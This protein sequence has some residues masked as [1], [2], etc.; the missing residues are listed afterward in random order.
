M[1]SVSEIE[2][3]LIKRFFSGEW[4]D[5]PKS[6]S[7]ASQNVR[8]PVGVRNSIEAGKFECPNQ[9]CFGR[10]FEFSDTRVFVSAAVPD[11]DPENGRKKNL[12]SNSW[13]S[14]KLDLLLTFL[15]VE[16]E[17]YVAVFFITN[18]TF[19]VKACAS[20]T[21]HFQIWEM[22]P[23]TLFQFSSYCVFTN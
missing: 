14:H 19:N 16:S 13:W 5:R 10:Y 2:F 7:Q 12:S 3:M 18:L 1:N 20:Q 4:T 6:F 17:N 8:Q 15:C 11:S 9:K 23:C 21:Q 22:N